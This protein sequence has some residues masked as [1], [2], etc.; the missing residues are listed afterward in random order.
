MNLNSRAFDDNQRRRERAGFGP[1]GGSEP[2]AGSRKAA[3]AAAAV[4]H[5]QG[6]TWPRLQTTRSHFPAVS[7][8]TNSIHVHLPLCRSLPWRNVSWSPLEVTR[9]L[10]LVVTTGPLSSPPTSWQ[11][12][13]RRHPRQSLPRPSHH[14]LLPQHLSPTH[15]LIG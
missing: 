2:A 9:F 10:L 8:E 15:T 3:S 11:L 1:Q 7:L 4:N 5:Q 13:R 12:E 6:Q 14:S